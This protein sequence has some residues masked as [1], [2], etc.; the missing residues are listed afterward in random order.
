MKSPALAVCL[1]LASFTAAAHAATLPG[2]GAAIDGQIKAREIAGA[3]TMVVTADRVLHR[4]AAGFADVAA[5]RPMP[6]DA[7]FW[8]ASMTKP[9]TGT[10]I[11][12]LQDEGRLSIDDPVEKH[13]PEFAGLRTPSEIGRAHV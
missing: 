10:A 12:I 2:I 11:L 4:Q 7:L 13:L 5:R 3:V 6:E 8:I 9:V 1:A